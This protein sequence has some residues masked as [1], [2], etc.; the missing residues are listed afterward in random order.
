MFSWILM[1]SCESTTTKNIAKTEQN[2]LLEKIDEYINAWV[3]GGKFN[4]SL[5]IAK[6]DSIYYYKSFGLAHREFNISNSDSTKYLIGSITKTFTAY[7]ILLLEQ[8]GKLSLD[9]R[10]S[11]YLPEFPKAESITIKQLLTHRSGITDYHQFKGWEENGRLDP[12]PQTTLS[13][14]LPNPSIFQPGE[15]FSY[16]N[17]G[18]IILGLIIEKVSGLSF[19]QFIR[20]EITEPLGLGNTGVASNKRVIENLAS[21]YT[22][23]LRETTNATYINYM[24]P[25]ASGN[26]YSTPIDLL[27]FTQSVMHS[28]LLPSEKTNEIFNSEKYYG[29]GWGIRDFNGVKAY[30]HYGAMNG[31]VGALTFIPEGEYVICFLT[32]DD[33]TPEYSI[34]EDLVKLINGDNIEPPI[35]KKMIELPQHRKAQVIGD[36]LVR[37]GDTLKIFELENKIYM[38]ESGQMRHELFPIDSLEFNLTLF[39]FNVVFSANTNIVRYIEVCWKEQS[40]SNKNS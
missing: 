3:L 38:Q 30:G 8:A 27:K 29:Y 20:S 24:Q 23:T 40:T 2:S 37:V 21:G 18:Y 19:D 14:L 32:N 4:G 12:T 26:M 34:T 7:G 5:L 9:D 11:A 25:Y 13:T 16:S 35:T 6:G 28:K 36:Y 22:T 17:S 15:R 31:F 39:E 1:S 33:N 10:L